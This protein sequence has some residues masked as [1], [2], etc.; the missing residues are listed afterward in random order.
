MLCVGVELVLDPSQSRC[1]WLTSEL[2]TMLKFG[3]KN[4]SVSNSLRVQQKNDTDLPVQS[5]FEMIIASFDILDDPEK[6]SYLDQI[7]SEMEAFVLAALLTKINGGNCFIIGAKN[8]GRT[9]E[10]NKNVANLALT[11]EPNLIAERGTCDV[12]FYDRCR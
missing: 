6:Y 12:D 11:L 7:S 2:A 9:K 5:I 8:C 1:R 3:V 10:V 4:L